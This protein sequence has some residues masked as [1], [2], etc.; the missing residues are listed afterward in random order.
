MQQL[1]GSAYYCRE[2]GQTADWVAEEIKTFGGEYI[3]IEADLS[4][5]NLIPKLF[6][7]AEEKWGKVDILVNNAAFADPDTFL[8]QSVL[9][10]DLVFAKE[11]SLKQL[12]AVTHDAHFYVNSRAVALMMTEYAKRHIGRH[13]RVD[14]LSI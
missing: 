13:D 11:Y 8:S 14:G 2:L 10:K 7:M 6:D 9:D 5:T 12:S 1:P 3:T 4:D